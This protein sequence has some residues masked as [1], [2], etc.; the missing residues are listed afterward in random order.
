MIAQIGRRWK[1]IAAKLISYGY[2]DRTMASVR[3]RFSRIEKARTIDEDNLKNK[4]HTCGRK[5]RGHTCRGDL[6]MVTGS[7]QIIEATHNRP[8]VAVESPVTVAAEPIDAR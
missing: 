3:N 7:P 8:V 4:C 1:A 5:K 2:T 6:P